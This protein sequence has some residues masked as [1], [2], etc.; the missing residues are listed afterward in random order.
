MNN[1]K[2][3]IAVVTGGNSGIGYATAKELKAQGA[4]VII[5]GRREEAVQQAAKA[6]GVTGIVADQSRLADTEN[7]V[8]QV[9]QDFGKVD[10]LFINAGIVGITPIEHATEQMF[11]DIININFRG[12]YFTLSR[13]IPLLADGGSVVFLSSNVASFNMANSSIYSS[14]KAALNSIMKIA[15]L[16][17]ASRNITVN[18]VSPGPTETEIL[19]KMGMDDDTLKAAKANILSKIPLNRMGTA[20][21]VASMVAYF[22]GDAARFITGA[23]ILMDGG[24]AL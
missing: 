17:L 7:L 13:F 15:A 11:D 9:K 14:S 19:N 8:A 18:A 16:E 1:L 24:M 5:T 12:A 4:K 23:E 10:I 20:Q 22:C 3:K 2:D 6:L 21:D